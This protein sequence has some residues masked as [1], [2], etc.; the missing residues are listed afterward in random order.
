[1]MSA[2]SP[3]L[4]QAWR[5]GRWGRQPTE[6]EGSYSPWRESM[7]EQVFCQ[8]LWPT[9]EPSRSGLILKDCLI[10]NGWITWK[11][12]HAGVIPENL[13]IWRRVY[14]GE[15]SEKGIYWRSFGKGCIPWEGPD[16]GAGELPKKEGM[17][18]AE[19]LL[20]DPNSYSPPRLCCLGERTQ[21]SQ[22]WRAQEDV[23]KWWKGIF[24]I[25]F[26]LS[27]S[28]SVINWH[29]IKLIF[30]RISLVYTSTVTGEQ[31]PCP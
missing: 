23:G 12:T 4:Q 7:Q 29:K 20:N 27:L 3:K 24:Q 28:H 16:T 10:L 18:E 2:K 8:E 14:I 25:C 9:G 21:K 30:P 15:V 13:Q 6:T 11:R 22:E 17:A 1:M 31:S 26:Y 5:I 19:V